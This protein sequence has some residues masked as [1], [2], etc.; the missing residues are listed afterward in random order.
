[1][2]DPTVNYNT[3]AGVCELQY[4]LP[5]A[6]QTGT[7][8]V[9]LTDSGGIEFGGTNITVYSIKFTSTGPKLAP[10]ITT[11][12]LP[13]GQM[14]AEYNE[15]LTKSGG[16]PPFTWEYVSGIIPNGL[17]L[18]TN[19]VISGTPTTL[20]ES[21]FTVKITD[22]NS[23]TDTQ[24]LSINIVPEPMGIVFSMIALCALLR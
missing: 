4:S 2:P 3:N 20:G 23:D 11:T 13:N 17:S 19:G 15:T 9:T 16:E 6:G 7:V 10:V 18:S 5:A 1:M 8:N 21:V 14:G 22:N 12:N 24:E